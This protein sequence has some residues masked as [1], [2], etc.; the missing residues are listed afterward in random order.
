MTGFEPRIS[1]YLLSEA[2]PLQTEPRHCP[3]FF[4]F[5]VSEKLDHEPVNDR[6]L[7]RHPRIESVH[8]VG[9]ICSRNLIS[10]LRGQRDLSLRLGLGVVRVGL[11]GSVDVVLGIAGSC[12]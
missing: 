7:L 1:G 9:R 11:L 3:Q 4:Y 2:T 5:L 10:V 6:T 12:Q 8:V